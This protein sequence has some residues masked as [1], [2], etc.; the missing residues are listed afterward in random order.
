MTGVVLHG[1]VALGTIA[2]G[3]VEHIGRDERLV[4]AVAIGV[5]V[6]L[7]LDYGDR[8]IGLVI[9]EVVG[10]ILWT[11]SVG[12]ASDDDFPGSEQ[13]LFTN[14]SVRLPVGRGNCGREVRGRDIAFDK[15]VFHVL[16]QTGKRIS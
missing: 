12:I 4:H 1:A 5:V 11:A 16:S 13:N 8:M 14:L 2:K 15:R 7:S 3:S 9:K 6:D 10:V